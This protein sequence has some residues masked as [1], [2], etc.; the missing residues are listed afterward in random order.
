MKLHEKYRIHKNNTN[1]IVQR[2]SFE[3]EIPSGGSQAGDI[4]QTS[5]PTGGFSGIS[6]TNRQSEGAFT[7]PC[8]GRATYAAVD[9][10]KRMHTSCDMP[11]NTLRMWLSRGSLAERRKRVRPIRE[12]GIGKLGGFDPCEFLLLRAELSLD[13]GK[14][15]N[16]FAGVSW[17]QG[18]SVVRTLAA[19]TGLRPISI[20]RFWISE[21]LTQAESYFQGVEFPGLQGSFQIA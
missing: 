2:I 6:A 19:W 13:A 17:S 11:W 12:V 10:A 1:L 9:D 15:P 8:E 20:L 21:G 5:C 3:K 4:S 16:F 7:V 18:F 14:F